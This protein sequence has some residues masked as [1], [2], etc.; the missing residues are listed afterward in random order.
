MVW[1]DSFWVSMWRGVERVCG[2]GGRIVM[3]LGGIIDRGVLG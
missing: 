3:E 2:V 1:E